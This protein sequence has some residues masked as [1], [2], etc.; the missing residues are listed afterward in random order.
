MK[1][2]GKKEETIKPHTHIYIYNH[3]YVNVYIC[4][5]I[6]VEMVFPNSPSSRSQFFTCLGLNFDEWCGLSL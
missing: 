5:H 6:R 4:L 2:I 1:N 3:T